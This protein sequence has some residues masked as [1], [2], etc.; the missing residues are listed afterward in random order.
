LVLG[1][2]LAGSGPPGRVLGSGASLSVAA[3]ASQADTGLPSSAAA[4]LIVSSISAGTG[5]D[6]FR[7]VMSAF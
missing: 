2:Q 5:I 1:H 6:S 7:T 4:A 3:S